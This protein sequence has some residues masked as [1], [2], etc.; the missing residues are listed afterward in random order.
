MATFVCRENPPWSVELTQPLW[1]EQ[2]VLEDLAMMNNMSVDSVVYSLMCL[3]HLVH[4]L[5]CNL[6][7]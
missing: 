2:L 5:P 7:Y 6:I 4:T 1:M 3:T